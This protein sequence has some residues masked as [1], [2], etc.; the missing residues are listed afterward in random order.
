MVYY[1]DEEESSN[2][3]VLKLYLRYKVEDTKEEVEKRSR[4]GSL[5]RAYD[6]E[7]ALRAFKTKTNSSPAKIVIVAQQNEYNNKLDDDSTV[8]TKEYEIEYKTAE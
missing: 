3:K 7:D 1:T 6:I 2:E 4:I 5:Y 8:Q